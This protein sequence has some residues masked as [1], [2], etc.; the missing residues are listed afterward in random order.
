MVTWFRE[1]RDAVRLTVWTLTVGHTGICHYDCAVTRLLPEP[2][3]DVFLVGAVAYVTMIAVYTWTWAAL[4]LHADQLEPT[5]ARTVLNVDCR[6]PPQ[7]PVTKVVERNYP[8][9]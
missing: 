1:H 4:A 8:V 6:R 7:F 3:R 5:T 2:H 9:D